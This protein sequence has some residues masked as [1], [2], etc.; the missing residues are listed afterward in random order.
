MEVSTLLKQDVINFIPQRKPM[1]MIGEILK[2]EGRIVETKL[3]ITEDNLF[4]EDGFFT[5]SGMLENIAQTAAS[6]VGVYSKLNN[7]E[8]PIG[9]I[10]GM[11]RVILHN[12]PKVGDTLI[13]RVETLQQVMNITLIAGKCHVA[14]QCMFECQMKIVINP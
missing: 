2:Y 9:F 13:T 10:G 6:G 12:S 8:V 4:S 1:V 14:Q 7:E 3:H 11:N 5:E